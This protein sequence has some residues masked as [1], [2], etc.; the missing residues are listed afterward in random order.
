MIHVP[1]ILIVPCNSVLI[2]LK[3]CDTV[4]HMFM[5][6]YV[7]TVCPKVTG[8][9]KIL[10]QTTTNKQPTMKL[11]DHMY[12]QPTTNQP[13]NQHVLTKPPILCDHIKF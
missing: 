7:R 3:M 8:L 12:K 2:K 10:D 1:R 6:I 9:I 5:Y 11:K 13:N 4:I